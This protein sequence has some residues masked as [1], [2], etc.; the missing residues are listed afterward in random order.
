MQTYNDFLASKQVDDK[1]TGLDVVPELNPMLFDFQ[2]DIV[3]WAL[4]RGRAAIFADCGLGKTPMQL[5]W[6]KHIEDVGEYV[7]SVL[8]VAPLA[9]SAQTVREGVKFGIEVNPCKTGADVKRGINITNYERLHH[10]DPE[11]FAGIVLDES[12]IL[13]SYTGKYRTDLVERWG[14]VPYRLC[15]T[16]TPAPNDYMELGNHAEFLGVMTGSEMLSS[17]FINDPGHVGHYRIKGHAQEP[18]WHWMCSW[19]VMVRKPSD[20]GYA[21]RDFILPELFVHHIEVETS[22]HSE[23]LFAVDAQTLQERIRARRDSLPERVAEAASLIAAHEDGEQWLCWCNLNKESER[24]V[25]SIPGAVEVRGSDSAEYKEE[26]VLRFVSGDIEKLVSKPKMFG[27]GLNLQHCHKMI[28]VGLSDSYEQYYQAVRRC[29]RF[30]QTKP[31]DCYIITA[32]TEGAVVANIR[33]KE[34]DA[35][36][37][38]EGM[39]KHMGYISEGII[40]GDAGFTTSYEPAQAMVLPEWS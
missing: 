11:D 12:A 31:V 9:V 10:F 22:T 3:R 29:W 6:A 17:F 15:C 18:F 36:Y 23:T 30:G 25:K 35:I 28:F 37:M 38:A 33:R 1:P 40:R 39:A 16:A 19:S 5:E 4:K 8:I 13:K 2:R 26:S 14:Q 24:L 32:D 21:D 20:L 27:H 7:G 34:R